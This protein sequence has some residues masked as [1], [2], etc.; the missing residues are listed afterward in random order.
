MSSLSGDRAA[1]KIEESASCFEGLDELLVKLLSKSGW[2][3]PINL[4]T[5][6]T[7]R[8]DAFDLL[9]EVARGK[10]S[11]VQL[12]LWETELWQWRQRSGGRV[13]RARN[14]IVNVSPEE[15]SLSRS[16]LLAEHTQQSQVIH[17]HQAVLAACKNVH[18]RVR[19]G[20][21]D[22][23]PVDTLGRL[24]VEER[25]RL[26]WMR[27]VVD[28]LTEAELPVVAQAQLTM[29]PTV[30]IER[31]VG[32]R[33]S[34]T[35]RSRVRVWNKV[36][37]WLTC[38]HQESWPSSVAH[39]VDY[40]DDV[41]RG[42]YGKSVPGSIAAALSFLESAGGVSQSQKISCNAFFM[43][44]VEVLTMQAQVGNT[45]T[46][47]APSMLIAVMIALELYICDTTKPKYKR[48]LCW[49]RNIRTWASMRADDMQGTDQLRMSYSVQCWRAVLT[50]TKTSG[51]GMKV[52]EVPIFVHARAGFTGNRWL[53]VGYDIWSNPPF[54]YSRDYFLP[55]PSRGWG[56]V[57]HKMAGFSDCS[58]MMRSL[59][60]E[61]EIPEKTA[62]GAWRSRALTQLIRAPGHMYWQEH[63]DR[64]FAPS[65]AAALGIAEH[66]RNF[67]GRWGIGAG[68]SNTYVATSRQIVLKIQ[69]AICT[70]ISTGGAYDEFDVINDYKAF[71]MARMP[72][73]AL[74]EWLQPLAV[75]KLDGSKFS[76]QQDWPMDASGAADVQEVIEEADPG[77]TAEALIKEVRMQETPSDMTYWMSVTKSGFRRLHRWR[78]CRV[79]PGECFAW[80]PVL[81]LN[82]DQEFGIADKPCKYCFPPADLGQATDR[83]GGSDS[84]TGSSGS[85]SSSSSDTAS[86]DLIGGEEEELG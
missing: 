20:Q 69:A 82:K 75:M 34:R 19:Q 29:N 73:V 72:G 28:I 81:E 14:R 42:S 84:D 16:L 86:S 80:E 23:K 15:R 36:R 67:L 12:G 83:G 30:A 66:E 55:L 40:L 79:Q 60:L 48:A 3:N 49:V 33:R 71:L 76:L 38:V 57:I 68:Q 17:I 26:K 25:D 27:K 74:D 43:N 41:S 2:Q 39:M 18:W 47:K 7:D 32:K 64:N 61:L 56:G 62:S 31:A 9:R 85:S 70:S 37:L 4:Y 63:S 59:M 21:T 58:G 52:Q 11:E 51:A 65:V 24:A 8:Q 45:A 22:G 54:N 1:R 5:A 10:A 13:Q 44:T 46:K 50:R 53:K 6:I 35:M 77:S 78:G